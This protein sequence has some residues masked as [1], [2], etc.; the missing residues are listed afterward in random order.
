MPHTARGRRGCKPWSRACAGQIRNGGLSPLPIGKW[1]RLR[2]ASSSPSTSTVA[3]DE[4]VAQPEALVREP[5]V[6]HVLR[7]APGYPIPY[8]TELAIRT[9]GPRVTPF[10]QSICM[11]CSTSQTVSAFEKV[12]VNVTQHRGVA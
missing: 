12:S 6:A 2:V 8:P 5:I 1:R 3:R 10:S 7:G 4:V 11:R 9:T